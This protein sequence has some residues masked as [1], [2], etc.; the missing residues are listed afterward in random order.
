[1]PLR[2]TVGEVL[3]EKGSV[4]WHVKPE[5]TVYDAL[6]LMAE[7]DIGALLVMSGAELIGVFSE[8]DYARKIRIMGKTSRETRVR[9]IISRSP[10]VVSPHET[11]DDCLHMMVNHRVHHLPIVEYQ[12]VIGLVSIG[13]LVH[14]IIRRQDRRIQELSE[15]IV[16]N[17]EAVGSVGG[18]G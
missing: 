15:H 1:M 2:D 17:A 11:V 3:Q 6:S 16:G 18:R 14:W 4:I 13:D 5:T 12:A 10:V 8:R 7:K 9:E